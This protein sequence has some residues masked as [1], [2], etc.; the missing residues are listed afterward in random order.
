MLQAETPQLNRAVDDNLLIQRLYTVRADELQE[1]DDRRIDVIC[2]TEYEYNQWFGREILRVDSE[3]VDLTRLNSGTSP[4]LLDH[5]RDGLKQVGVVENARIVNRQLLTTLRFSKNPLGDEIYRDILDG[6]RSQ[7]SNGYR[8]LSYEVDDSNRQDPLYTITNW[9]PYE[10]SVVTVNADPESLVRRG[11]FIPDNNNN[12]RAAGEPN[13]GSEM[14]NRGNPQ[15]NQGNPQ[16]QQRA[17]EVPEQNQQGNP[18]DQN[19]QDNPQDQNPEQN[20][21][22]DDTNPEVT[23]VNPSSFEIYERGKQENEQS[24]AMEIIGQRGSLEDFEKAL[25]DK[26]AAIAAEHNADEVRE[27]QE[28][29]RFN[30]GDLIFQQLEPGSERGQ[31]ELEEARDLTEDAKREGYVPQGGGLVIPHSRLDGVPER[32]QRDLTTAANSGGTLVGTDV[33]GDL[34][35]DALRNR[36]VLGDLVN[37]VTGLMGN[38][39]IPAETTPAT[40]A[41]LGENETATES[42]PVIGQISLVPKFVR[43]FTEISRTLIAQASV[44][45]ERVIRNSLMKGIALV[46]DK[47]ILTGSGSGDEPAGIDAISGLNVVNYGASADDIPTAL[48]KA[49]VANLTAVEN[50]L[51]ENNADEMGRAWVVSPNIRQHYRA[52]PI[53]TGGIP[54]WFMGRLLDEM[55]Y[56]TNQ[57]A[58]GEAYFGAWMDCYVGL[59]DAI[60][61]LVNPFSGDTAGRVRI[62]GWQMAGFGFGHGVS[63]AKLAKTP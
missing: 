43:G 35:I 5:S 39:S 15:G 48:A 23:V 26:R 13:R 7:I 44:D 17:L 60:E 8:I 58:S 14:N 54:S 52:V 46:V 6:I 9:L 41:W 1:N 36:M 34:F 29:N 10:V 49:T 11:Y 4:V 63:F 57:A 56:V 28:R 59:W 40:A 38:A 33:R 47:A 42:N 2:A 53:G 50:H 61:L 51:D 18:Q 3:S 45:V 37:M 21:Q 31:R 19:P 12:Y 24:L 20:A 25:R 62:T 22:R 32:G 16:L 27:E 55:A 30:L